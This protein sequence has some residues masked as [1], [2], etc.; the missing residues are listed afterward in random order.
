MLQIWL[1]ALLGLLCCLIIG[2]GMIGAFYG[3]GKDHWS[4]SEDVWEGGFG[5][6]ASLVITLMG[7]ALLR[8]SKLQDK[9]RVKL[10]KALEAKHSV[11]TGLAKS[12]FKLWCEKY[13][14]FVLP[15]ITVL[16]EG[17]EAVVF[18]GGVGLGLPATSF[19]LAVICGVAAGCLIG[20]LI[21]K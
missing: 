9:W 14:M 10:A 20:F 13:A 16:R 5:L 3:L 6:V 17:L 1:G 18:I 2:A 8:I 7:A 4:S 15:F 19:P 12:R 11:R 21:Y